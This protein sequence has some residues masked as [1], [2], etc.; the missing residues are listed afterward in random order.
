MVLTL[1]LDK[2]FEERE[3]VQK[4][5]QKLRFYIDNFKPTAEM[6]HND[7]EKMLTFLN[8]AYECHLNLTETKPTVGI[9]NL[10]FF[11]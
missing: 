11:F 9:G 3:N 4:Q 6:Q 5:F 10:G 7:R 1:W 2:V 8:Q